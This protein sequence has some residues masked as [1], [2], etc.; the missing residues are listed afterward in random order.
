MSHR[1][2]TICITLTLAIALLANHSARAEENKPCL[3]IKEAC[4]QTGF[5]PGSAGEGRGLLVDCI[6]PIMDNAPRKASAGKPLP[7]VD[8]AIVAACKTKNPEFGKPKLK[9]SPGPSASGSDF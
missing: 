2:E 6:R 4:E 8:A 9:G 5:K 7:T 3:K 1:I